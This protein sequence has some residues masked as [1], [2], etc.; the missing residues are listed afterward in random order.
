MRFEGKYD[1]LWQGIDWDSIQ[2]KRRWEEGP[3]ETICEDGLYDKLGLKQKDEMKK[4][5]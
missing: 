2:I 3:Q 5:P 1:F 4:K